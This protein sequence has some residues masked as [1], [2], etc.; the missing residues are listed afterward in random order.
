ME[1]LQ[2]LKTMDKKTKIVLFFIATITLLGCG[3]ESSTDSNPNHQSTAS[4]NNPDYEKYIIDNFSEI[5]SLV[6]DENFDDLETFGDKVGNHHIV[7]L[8]ESTH[9]SKQMNQMKTRLIKYLHQ[10][11]DFNVIAF[12]S[13]AFSCNMQPELK[14]DIDAETLTKSCVYG[15]WQTEEVKELFAYILKTQSTEHPLRLSGF[16]IKFSSAADN[17]ENMIAFYESVVEQFDL[18][19]TVD[20]KAFSQLIVAYNSARTGCFQ[21]NPD[22]CQFLTNSYADARIRIE[23]FRDSFIGDEPRLQLARIIAN[24]YTYLIEETNHDTFNIRDKGMAAILTDLTTYYLAD[25]KVIV[26]AHNA[27]IAENL[28]NIEYYEGM[29]Y[30]LKEFWQ[31]ELYTVGLFMIKGASANNFRE[32][33]KVGAHNIDSLESLAASVTKDIIFL[34]FTTINEAGLEDDWLHTETFNKNW[35]AWNQ[36]T[37][38]AEAYDAVVIIE[39]S[40]MPDYLD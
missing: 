16:D 7:Q 10:Y 23:L 9:G 11:H 20:I 22:D 15:V 36:K 27:H 8:G 5:T 6:N 25:D 24:S 12:E 2:G 19:N 1:L 4:G 26:W 35:G 40:T 34:P 39:N 30:Y 18:K 13:S 38:L 33:V 17:E 28:Y 31:D 29:G 3:S 32:S 37:I 14:P 21:R